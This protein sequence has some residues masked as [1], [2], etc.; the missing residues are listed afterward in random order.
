M[1][2]G[3][4]VSSHGRFPSWS[5]AFKPRCN[6]LQP[7]QRSGETE[8]VTTRL[9]ANQGLVAYDDSLRLTVACGVAWGRC[10]ALSR[11]LISRPSAFSP[12]MAWALSID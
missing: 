5:L 6:T 12:G 4:L 1:T 2:R 3:G 8:M 7:C 11:D 9:F 10:S